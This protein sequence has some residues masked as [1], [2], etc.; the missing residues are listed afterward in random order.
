MEWDVDDQDESHEEPHSSPQ[1]LDEDVSARGRRRREAVLERKIRIVTNAG[2]LNP[3]GLAAKISGLAAGLGLSPQVAYL[4]GDDLR[5]QL[6][7]LLAAGHDL[8]HL[9][10]GRS[11]RQA[12]V[13]PITANAYLGSWG[14]A[15]ALGEG[16]DIVVC[17]RVTDASLAVGPAAWWHGWSR[18]DYDALAGAVVAGHVIECG[19]QATGGNYPWPEEIRDR[20]YPGF[21]IAEIEADGASVITK[22]VVQ[23]QPVDVGEGTRGVIH[24]AGDAPGR[25]NSSTPYPHGR[26]RRVSGHGARRRLPANT[27]LG[28]GHGRAPQQ[29]R[30]ANVAVPPPTRT[31]TPLHLRFLVF[32]GDSS[33]AGGSII[34]VLV[35]EPG[36]V[37]TVEVGCPVQAQLLQAGRGEAG[38]IPFVADHHD[39][40]IVIHHPGQPV[41]A[42]GIQSPFENIAIDDDGT[43][44]LAVAAALVKRADVNDQCAHGAKLG[45]VGR[46]RS[47]GKGLARLVQHCLDPLW[48]G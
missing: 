10:T 15:A 46:S 23:L 18:T 42:A 5:S 6:D 30:V 32:R 48:H 17:G 37:T 4:D 22:L 44:E 2:G 41:R 12:G 28:D 21:P 38:R 40:P 14:I 1:G 11:L 19:P 13:V 45:H 27:Q 7:E 20:R 35:S 24:A 8:T 34:A 33:L 16:A 26:G 25:A 36:L 47:G 39:Q 29:F 31:P 43:G 9:D 3:A